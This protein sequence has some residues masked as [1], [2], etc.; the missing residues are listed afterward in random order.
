[1]KLLVYILLFFVTVQ[2]NGQVL[3][4]YASNFSIEDTNGDEHRL[5]EYLDDGKFVVLE[6]SFASCRPCKLGAPA[7]QK[8]FREYG[9]NQG[10]VIFLGLNQ[11][12][13]NAEIKAYQRNF[14]L[15]YP[16]A[17]I[18][19]STYSITAQYGVKAFP[20]VVLIAP[21]RSF[22]TKDIYPVTIQNL[23]TALSQAK[24]PKLPTVCSMVHKK[25]HFNEINFS[26]SPNPVVSGA[27]I[28]ISLVEAMNVRVD[29]LN[30]LGQKILTPIDTFL[31]KPI[32][33]Y[34][35][36]DD[37]QPGLYLIQLSVNGKVVRTQRF[38]KIAP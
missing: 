9:C 31:M 23:E 27:T 10:D 15:S 30:I 22:V 37:L 33:K 32:S 14:G 36:F 7:I 18:E 26:V 17:S 29:I 3:I 21:D 4:H 5:Y 2:L 12:D 19:R 24:I 34:V 13:S 28:N 38:S 11:I 6:F 35:D 16:M 20:T 8:A 25:R 1:M